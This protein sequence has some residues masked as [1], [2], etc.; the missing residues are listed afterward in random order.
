[1][2]WSPDGPHILFAVDTSETGWGIWHYSY[3]DQN[4]TPL[5]TSPLLDSFLQFSPDGRWFAYNSFG[6]TAQL[7]VESFPR[8]HGKWQVIAGDGEFP[9][10]SADGRELLLFSLKERGQ[11]GR[12]SSMR[13]GRT[14]SLPVSPSAAACG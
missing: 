7:I 10:W 8:G 4:A 14:W 12:T 1:M 3:A 13:N 9:R 6:V 5:A 2:S 11:L